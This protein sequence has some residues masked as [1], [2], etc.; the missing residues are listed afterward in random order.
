MLEASKNTLSETEETI[1]QQALHKAY[2]RETS[3]LIAN[4][5]ERANSITKLE[6]LWYLH[7]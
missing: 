1:A 2:E 3:A 5:R 4:V 6:D 7:D